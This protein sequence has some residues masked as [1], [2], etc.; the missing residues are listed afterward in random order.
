MSSILP[1]WDIFPASV[2]IALQ[3]GWSFITLAKAPS[4]SFSLVVLR[5]I[6]EVNA[7]QCAIDSASSGNTQR[8]GRVFRLSSFLGVP[9][10]ASH[11]WNY[12]RRL[13]FINPWTILCKD[14]SIVDLYLKHSL[15]QLFQL[16]SEQNEQIWNNQ[17]YDFQKKNMGNFPNKNPSHPKQLQDLQGSGASNMSSATLMRKASFGS[18]AFRGGANL[19]D[20]AISMVMMNPP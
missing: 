2:F 14:V 10:A 3:P 13:E 20:R 8:F 19:G 1:A 17:K 18:S 5:W 15:L 6:N 4:R 7:I 16:F 9:N 11:E 12:Y